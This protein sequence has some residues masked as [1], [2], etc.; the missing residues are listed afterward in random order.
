MKRSI[1]ILSSLLLVFSCTKEDKAT[2]HHYPI[3]FTEQVTNIHT[4]GATF[5]GSFLQPGK[6]EVIDH[7]FVFSTIN[8]PVFDN[9]VKI[10]L[11]ASTGSGSF[12]CTANAGM[13]TGQTYW[14]SAYA[15]NRE[16]VFF[17]EPVS[18]VVK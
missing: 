4:G 7:G 15:Q 11:G 17:A 6:G 9:D 14:V 5:N 2:R 13:I 10:S 16:K 8:W 3:V 12:T 1:L 18:F